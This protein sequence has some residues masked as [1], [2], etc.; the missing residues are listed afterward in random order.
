[1]NVVIIGA[2]QGLGLELSQKFLAGGTYCG[3]G[4]CGS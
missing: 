2:T 1:M 4:R 3:G